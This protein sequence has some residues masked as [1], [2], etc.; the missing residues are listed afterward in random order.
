MYNLKN[1]CPF[2][3]YY[4]CEYP[5]NAYRT[6]EDTQKEENKQIAEKEAEIEQRQFPEAMPEMTK[7]PG[8][9]PVAMPGQYTFNPAEILRLIEMNN[10]EIIRT[11]MAYGVPLD[12]ARRIVMMIIRL[13]LRYH[14]E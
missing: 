6:E 12:T 1:Y 9:P 14:R 11:M 5:M 3:G 8:M 2:A 10:P 4:A 7:I 13:V